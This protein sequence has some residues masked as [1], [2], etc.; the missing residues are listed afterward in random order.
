[1]QPRLLFIPVSGGRGGGELQ[2]C[3]ILARTL[4]AQSGDA[5]DIRFVVH[6]QAP[7]PHEH[8]GVA[9]RVQFVGACGG[10]DYY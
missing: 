4:R 10:R 5:V 6:R 3:L 7:F 1:M 8:A 9:F 2:R